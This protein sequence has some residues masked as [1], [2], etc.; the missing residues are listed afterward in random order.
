MT[1]IQPIPQLSRT[2]ADVVLFTIRN[3]ALYT[4][5]V[6][7]PIFQATTPHPNWPHLF[8]ADNIL[9]GVACTE[10]YQFCNRHLC[11]DFAALYQLR[12]KTP[13]VLNLNPLQT[14]IFHVIWRGAQMTRLEA[15]GECFAPLQLFTDASVFLRGSDMLI[16]KSQVFGEFMVSSALADNQWQIEVLNAFNISLAKSQF[17][18]PMYVSNPD[19]QIGGMN[20]KDFIVAPNSTEGKKIC[21]L[22]KMRSATYFSFNLFGLL[23]ILITGTVVIILGNVVPC[24]V[25]R[26]RKKRRGFQSD[27][28]QDAWNAEDVLVLQ[29]KAF[30]SYGAGP[31]TMKN[32]VPVWVGGERRDF[33]APWLVR[34]L[35]EEVWV[36]AARVSNRLEVLFV[37]RAQD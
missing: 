35:D 36:W 28:R 37:G 25:D 10:T 27:Y 19:I 4:T 20:F 3:R 8:K 13:E 33:A 15:L 7:D 14:S 34:D 16:A 26:Y 24:L 12:D 1:S 11:S 29:S 9:T 17:M 31:W 22:Q 2:D 30:E 32:N 21:H 23:F 5:P 18:R 6:T